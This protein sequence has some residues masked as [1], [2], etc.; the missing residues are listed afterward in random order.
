M[1]HERLGRMVDARVAKHAYATK[2]VEHFMQGLDE[3]ALVRLGASAHA[4]DAAGRFGAD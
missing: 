2:A 4:W 3:F 1:V